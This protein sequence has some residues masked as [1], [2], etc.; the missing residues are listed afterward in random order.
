MVNEEIIPKFISAWNW[1]LMAIIFL[2]GSL[3][4]FSM[5][6]TLFSLVV[7]IAFFFIFI[8]CESITIK[9]RREVLE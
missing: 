1:Q 8:I 9:R 4:V 3:I 7:G 2:V 6:R 5:P